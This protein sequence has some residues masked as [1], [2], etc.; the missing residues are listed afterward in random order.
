MTEKEADAWKLRR[1]AARQR[2][3]R[4]LFAIC[5]SLNVNEDV[6]QL[7]LR[8]L[9]EYRDLFP[10]TEIL[11]VLG[12]IFERPRLPMVD[13]YM[14]CGFITDGPSAG[15]IELSPRTDGLAKLLSGNWDIL[16]TR[17]AV[18]LADFIL[19]VKTV[20][21]VS[22]EVLANLSDLTRGSRSEQGYVLAPDAARMTTGETIATSIRE[23]D[24]RF[25]L[26]VLSLYG[27]MHEKQELRV[28]EIIITRDGSLTMDGFRT[29]C[30][31]VFS[32]V[33][34]KWY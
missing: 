7:H 21:S 33:P 6:T 5:Q 2:E 17:S 20:G 27:W 15:F 25:V 11:A 8:P 24:G 16:G 22:H 29:L 13:S 30:T 1:R 4:L 23:F 31:P 9:R 10:N 18:C 34:E 19:T 32:E 12:P 14:L 28:T 26:Q 3:E